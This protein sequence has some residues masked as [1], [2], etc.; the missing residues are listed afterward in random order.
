MQLHAA[1]GFSGRQQRNPRGVP[2]RN[3]SP[4]TARRAD[5][6]TQE[7]RREVCATDVYSFSYARFKVSISIFTILSTA[8]MTRCDLAGSLS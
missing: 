2:A 8:F 7:R 6:A 3:L 5:S 1:A 4:G